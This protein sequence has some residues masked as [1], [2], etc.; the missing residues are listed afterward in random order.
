MLKKKHLSAVLTLLFLCSFLLWL[1]IGGEV[2]K[3]QRAAANLPT[4]SAYWNA[5]EKVSNNTF[6][7]TSTKVV[8][9]SLGVVH[10]VWSSEHHAGS[11]YEY[12]LEHR[13]YSNGAWS[14]S[15]VIVEGNDASV[16]PAT[17][18]FDVVIDSSGRVYVFWLIH[19]QT[20]GDKIC[21]RSLDKSGWSAIEEA[22]PAE[23]FE[24]IQSFDV[25]LGKK[26][27]L[28]LFVSATLPHDIES[29]AN[30]FYRKFYA[31]SWS[32]FK[33]I[34]FFDDK[35]T[36]LSQLSFTATPQDHLYGLFV[37][38]EAIDENRNEFENQVWYAFYNSE[39]W[40]D[41]IFFREVEYVQNITY[42]VASDAENNFHIIYTYYNETRLYYEK[43]TGMSR[44]LPQH[45]VELTLGDPMSERYYS[46]LGAQSLIVIG[47]EMFVFYIALEWLGDNA[48]DYGVDSDLFM[49]HY[50]NDSWG[51]PTGLVTSDEFDPIV[52]SAAADHAGSL[53]IVWVDE[54]YEPGNNTREV[55]YLRGINLFSYQPTFA[56]INYFLAPGTLVLA[57]FVLISKWKKRQLI[58]Y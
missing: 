22:C 24:K 2:A 47:S 17:M 36:S 27:T 3:A 11:T 48:P 8:A 19:H 34:T 35:I 58:K 53:S 30:L 20:Q 10:V 18:D 45:L 56:G 1:G 51:E 54:N 55:Y 43:T 32:A 33:R 16:V 46:W 39:E 29:G 15:F 44:T 9:D 31:S 49:L 38:Q 14:K 21:W 6:N 41:G 57:L 7:C 23:Q 13:K 52:V 50:Q 40:T 5:P 4:P 26:D 42:N 28:H 12:K 37:R 25:V